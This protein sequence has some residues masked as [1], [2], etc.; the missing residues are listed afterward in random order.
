VRVGPRIGARQVLLG[1]FGLC[2][3]LGIGALGVAVFSSTSAPRYATLEVIS[4]PTGATVSV[5]GRKMGHTPVALERVPLQRPLTLRVELDRHL[6]WEREERFDEPRHVKIV[7]SLKPVLGTLRVESSPVGAEV[8]IDNRSVGLTP[9]LRADLSPFT[10][11]VVEVRKQGFKPQRLPLEWKG[12]RQ[13][14][15]R[16]ELQPAKD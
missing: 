13:V 11:A 14:S 7:A 16:V 2:G 8:F 10:D 1:L 12:Q 15:L 3:L 5:D 6:A 4:I 9:L